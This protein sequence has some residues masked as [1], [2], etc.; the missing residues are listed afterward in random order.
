MYMSATI[1]EHKTTT[2]LPRYI[3]SKSINLIRKSKVSSKSTKW[4][5]IY[6]IKKFVTNIFKHPVS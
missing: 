2:L 6:T 1:T 3:K 5:C 4:K